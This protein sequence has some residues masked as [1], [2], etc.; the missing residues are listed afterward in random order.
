MENCFGEHQRAC[1]KKRGGAPAPGVQGGGKQGLH[2]ESAA[3]TRPVMEGIH[4]AKAPLR[5]KLLGTQMD[6]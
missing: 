3:T 2:D 6:T 4:K 1:S 5:S